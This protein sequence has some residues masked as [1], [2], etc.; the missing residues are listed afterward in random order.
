MI[1]KHENKRKA[2]FGKV[3]YDYCPDCKQEVVDKTL[4]N[5]LLNKAEKILVDDLVAG[6][7]DDDRY[8]KVK[9]SMDDTDCG[10]DEVYIGYRITEAKDYTICSTTPLGLSEGLTLDKDAYYPEYL[11]VSNSPVDG[12]LHIQKSYMNKL[13]NL[14]TGIID[15][16]VDKKTG[17]VRDDFRGTHVIRL[18]QQLGYAV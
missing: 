2:G 18:L 12:W 16:V 3:T 6:C 17:K 9:K 8:Y 14:K 4:P 5:E 10:I 11:C 13:E 7:F 1:C 15:T